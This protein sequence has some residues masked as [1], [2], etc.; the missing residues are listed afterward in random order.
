M[1]YRFMELA[2]PLLALSGLYVM[3]KQGGSNKE[4]FKTSKTE[5]LPNTDVP[6]VNYPPDEPIRTEM[7]DRTSTLINDNRYD[8]GSV[9]TDKFFNPAVNTTSRIS[10]VADDPST[11][12]GSDMRVQPSSSQKQSGSQYYSMT[13]E[14]VDLDYFQHN[15]MT[16]YF[17]GQLRN[18]I[19]NANSSESQLDAMN[20]TGSQY[21]SKRENSPLF[22]PETNLEWPLGTPNN[23]DFVRSRMN[24]S[25]RMANVNPFKEEKVGPGLGLGFTTAGEGGFNAGMGMRDAWLDRGVDE[26]RVATKP[27]ASGMMALGY[28]GPAYSYIKTMASAEQMGAVEK[29]RPETSFPMGPERLMTTTGV[30][31]GQ[32]LRSIPVDRYVSRPET[33]I[34]YA[35]GAGYTNTTKEMVYGE[36]MPTHN[37]ALGEVPIPVANANGRGYG[38]DADYG[39]KASQVYANNRSEN[40]AGEYFGGLGGS[41]GAVVAPLLDMLRPSRRENTIGTLRPYQNPG[42]TVS[43]SYIFNPADRA[44]TTIRETTER[45]IG[46]LN[47]DKTL[48]ERGAYE[49]TPVEV[50]D[51]ARQTTSRYYLGNAGASDRTKEARPYDAEYAQRNNENKSSAVEQTAYMT[52]GSIGLLNGDIN[53]R[54]KPREVADTRPVM[55]TM[56]YQTVD[57]SSMGLRKSSPGLYSNIELDRAHPDILSGLKTNPYAIQRVF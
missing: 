55:P 33:A 2:I 49:V 13:G 7:W 16:P 24:V 27:K 20:G 40:D 48:Y 14:K 8:G 18:K 3:S 29:N 5:E 56:P 19:T 17:G 6:D 46:H 53:M 25:W 15:N 11:G 47:T 23:T 37:H 10:S 38:T 21:L 57:A 45:A 51:T 28:E 4:S 42:S 44:P 26:L 30:E 34:A 41:I 1:I 35:G 39:I 12:N 54:T 9:Y 43:Q 22:A 31:K 32:T 36:Y 52:K 50:K